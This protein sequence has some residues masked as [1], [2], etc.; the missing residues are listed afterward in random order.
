[1]SGKETVTL[2]LK[3]IAHA[4]TLK[5]VC[6]TS[7]E[8]GN[9]LGNVTRTELG[10][11]LDERR[12]TE[13]P[14]AIVSW[15]YRCRRRGQET[16]DTGPVREG[17]G[18][19]TVQRPALGGNPDCARTVRA[20]PA[21][22]KHRHPPTH[23]NP[24]QHRSSGVVCP[25]PRKEKNQQRAVMCQPRTVTRQPLTVTCQPLTV[26]C[27]L[28]TVTC[29]LL[30]VARQPLTSMCQPLTV[31]RQ[32]LTVTRQ[33]LKVNCQPLRMPTNGHLTVVGGFLRVFCDKTA[34]VFAIAPRFPLRA[35]RAHFKGEC[36]VICC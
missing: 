26:T 11:G 24:P 33:P 31:M 7:T 16:P 28:L 10:P 22:R 29:Q 34:A 17:E 5:S 21:H 12:P 32:P 25:G 6:D 27:Q 1:M 8:R 15:D 18:N 3:Y 30:T 2:P 19:A 23:P 9:R 35:P 20:P 14:F 36:K 13:H 4:W